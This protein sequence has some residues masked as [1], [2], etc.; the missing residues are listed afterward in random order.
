MAAACRQRR[1]SPQDQ[2]ELTITGWAMEA[3]LY[4][5]NPMTGFLPST[6]P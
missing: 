4:A 3:C 2:D 6:G 1:V 5:E